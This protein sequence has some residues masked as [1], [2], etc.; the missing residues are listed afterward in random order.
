MI[1]RYCI[2]VRSFGHLAAT[3]ALMAPLGSVAATEGSSFRDQFEQLDEERWYVSHGWSNGDHQ[4]CLWSKRQVAADGALRLSFAEA[5]SEIEGDPTVERDYVC[6]EVQTRQRFGYGTFE[7]RLKA[8]DRSGYN[9]A[10]FTYIGPVHDQ[11]HDEIDVEVLGRDTDRVEFNQFVDGRSAGG[12]IVD[13][14]GGTASKFV[15]YAFIWEPERL[16]Y[17]VDGELVHEVLDPAVIP[18]QPMKIY[19]SLWAG[20]TNPGWMGQFDPPDGPLTMEIDWIAFTA[21]GEPCHFPE[22]VACE[23]R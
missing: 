14:P 17:F 15:S 7:V 16:R 23:A 20:E 19:S 5:P 11:P 18:D 9:S 4:N 10:F 22:S 8:V 13:V 3:V 21:I 1:K 6:A 12:T 2:F